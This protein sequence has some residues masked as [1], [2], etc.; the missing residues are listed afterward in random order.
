M[1]SIVPG[2]IA[3]HGSCLL[4]RLGQLAYRWQEE[5]LAEL[6]LRVRHYS[7]LQGLHDAG[8]IVQLELGRY[9]GIDPATMVAALDQLETRGAVARERS[10]ED[11]RRYV[12]SLTPAG[13]K[14]LAQAR[15]LLDEVDARISAGLSDPATARLWKGLAAL[16]D[17]L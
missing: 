9:L 3:D 6:D 1:T 17:S 16:A 15:A 2:G 4:V 11:K 8:P 14:L 12:V 13:E 5:R 10:T 7:V